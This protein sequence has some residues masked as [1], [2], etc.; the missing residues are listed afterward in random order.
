MWRMPHGFH[1]LTPTRGAR[2]PGTDGV[3]ALKKERVGH[4]GP[5]RQPNL[6]GDQSVP[7]Q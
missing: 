6:A 5:P 1:G 2:L 4:P 3:L 7:P